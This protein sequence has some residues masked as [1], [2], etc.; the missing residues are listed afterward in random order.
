MDDSTVFGLLMNRAHAMHWK[1][2][3]DLRSGMP[4]LTSEEIPQE[5]FRATSFDDE[6]ADTL[7]F[8]FNAAAN[9]ARVSR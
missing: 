1:D 4:L 5:V 6:T 3:N 8:H 7:A 2:A 9:A